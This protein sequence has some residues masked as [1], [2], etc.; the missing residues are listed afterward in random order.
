MLAAQAWTAFNFPYKISQPIHNRT[1]TF[2]LC[3]LLL[4]AT[5][6]PLFSWSYIEI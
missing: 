2:T 6:S 4:A 5:N 3:C 1:N